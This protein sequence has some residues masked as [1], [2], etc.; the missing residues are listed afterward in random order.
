MGQVLRQPSQIKIAAAAEDQ[1]YIPDCVS[2]FLE[3]KQ[4]VCYFGSRSSSRSVVL[5]G[6]SHA[7]HWL[8]AFKNIADAKNLN[9]MTLVKFGCPVVSISVFQPILGRR[10]SECDEWRG[11]AIDEILKLKPSVVI[12][13]NAS[14]YEAVTSSS[15][16]EHISGDQ[17]RDAYRKI[18]RQFAERGISVLVIRDTPK[19]TFDPLPCL[20]RT[21]GSCRYGDCM[22]GTASASAG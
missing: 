18:F 7:W 3:T 13:S 19:M 8:P 16:K 10:Y 21:A 2:S 22:R 1:V 20:S 6:D 4:E 5:F 9:L 15:R 17:W 11:P 12:L 14:D